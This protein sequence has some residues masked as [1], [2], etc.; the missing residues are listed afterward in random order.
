MN[1]RASLLFVAAA[2]G[3]RV[4]AVDGA[5]YSGPKNA[6]ELGCA[7]GVGCVDGA[8]VSTETAYPLVFE[9][10]PQSTSTFAR[11]VTFT[12]P[13]TDRKGGSDRNLKLDEP[14]RVV[15]QL[16]TTKGIKL[17]LRKVDAVPGAAPAV[18]EASSL[19]DSTV[20][21]V[22]TV[23]PG[24]YEVFLTPTTDSDLPIDPPVQ[25]RDDDT[26]LPLVQTFTSGPQKLVVSYSGL[27]T[28]DVTLTDNAGALL[29]KPLNEARDVFVVDETTGVLA[30]TIGHSCRP[31]AEL[32]DSNVKLTLAPALTGHRYTLRVAPAA[33]ACSAAPGPLAT[34]DFDLDTLDVEGHGNRAALAMPPTNRINAF[35]QVVAFGSNAPINDATIILRSQ[36]GKLDPPT[37][38][39]AGNAFIEARVTVGGSDGQFIA[40][41]LLAGTYRATVIP[42]SSLTLGARPYAICVDCTT[43]AQDESAPPGSRIVDFKLDGKNSVDFQIARRVSVTLGAA[44]F[45]GALFGLGTFESDTSSSASLT[46]ASGTALITRSEAGTLAIT[47]EKGTPKSW[48]VA[49]ALDPGVYDFVVRTPQAS[50]YPWVVLP[51]VQVAPAPKL[52]LGVVTATAPV[53]F[54]GHIVDPTGAP[55]P[56]ANLRARAL[57][58]DKTDPKK[59]PLGAVLVGE[60]R[61]GEDGSYRIVL[62]SDFAGLTPTAK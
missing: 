54:E 3:C 19:S 32:L 22:L 9:V 14:A 8:C 62:P 61:T 52:E 33:T 42:G 15:A 60:T 1:A 5:A 35:G 16:G 11:G 57:I 29:T 59:P 38:Y 24:D 45:D 2:L 7:S 41:N 47:Q 56:R 21:Q 26:K 12:V 30:S 25:L 17:R 48:N 43:S 44:G 34:V 23:P 53:I 4:Q 40:R 55:V 36:P 18:F 20:T 39:T 28:I 46:N 13:I 49:V 51:S 27:R 50:G 10:T 58:P 6:C 31:G 37:D